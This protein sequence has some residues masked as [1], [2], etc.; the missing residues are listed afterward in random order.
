VWSPPPPAP[1]QL[2][3]TGLLGSGSRAVAMVNGGMISAGETTTV[4][5][6][7]NRVAL[8]CLSITTNQVTLE[9]PETGE[10]VVLE[11]RPKP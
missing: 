5:V 8:R 1:E 7:T 4:R 3:L 6:G 10:R 2:N 11:W 9:L